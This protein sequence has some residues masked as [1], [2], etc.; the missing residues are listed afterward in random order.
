MGAGDSFKARLPHDAERRA[1]TTISLGNLVLAI[2]LFW[3]AVSYDDPKYSSRNPEGARQLIGSL[4][5]CQSVQGCGNRLCCGH[6]GREG[7]LV[8]KQVVT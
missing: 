4:D 7:G 5:I 8:Q 2:E 6:V 1:T 3:V